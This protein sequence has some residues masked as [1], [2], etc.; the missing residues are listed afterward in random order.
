[1][2]PDLRAPGR[3]VDREHDHDSQQWP[4]HTFTDRQLQ[5]RARI[6][7]GQIVE[8]LHVGLLE[9]R[10]RRMVP[11]THA[12]TV[13]LD[14]EQRLRVRGADCCQHQTRALQL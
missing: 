13:G 6:Q 12:G 14:R 10:P 8:D 11:V 9:V 2:I 1:V 5:L 3:L 7:R 4:V